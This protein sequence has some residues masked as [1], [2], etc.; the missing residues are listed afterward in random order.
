MLIPCFLYLLRNSKDI[1]TYG[2]KNHCVEPKY[3]RLCVCLF[4][5]ST[6]VQIGN[7]VFRGV[8]YWVNLLGGCYAAKKF[9]GELCSLGDLLMTVLS[10]WFGF[11]LPSL[12]YLPFLS[13]RGCLL[14]LLCCKD[15]GKYLCT[16]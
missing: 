15:D 12:I 8:V 11:F 1:Q 13:F 16:F 5:A 6:T 14:L 3:G 2:K 4:P 10:F 9:L 7:F